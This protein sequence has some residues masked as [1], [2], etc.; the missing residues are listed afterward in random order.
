MGD[1]DVQAQHAGSP[2]RPRSPDRE[3]RQLQMKLDRQSR[4]LA[5]LEDQF[6]AIKVD[7][8]E[9]VAALEAQLQL[10]AGKAEALRQEVRRLRSASPPDGALSLAD[11]AELG[12][13]RRQ[14]ETLQQRLDASARREQAAAARS[15]DE[16]AAERE[17]LLKDTTEALYEWKEEC[18]HLQDLLQQHDR[19]LASA[20]DVSASRDDARARE[21]ELE[22]QAAL[23]EAGQE[24]EAAKKQSQARWDA[25]QIEYAKELE[26]REKNAGFLL[27]KV[28][29]IE[30]ELNEQKLARREATGEAQESLAVALEAGASL[31]RAYAA[32]AERCRQLQDDADVADND[33]SVLLDW[34]RSVMRVFSKL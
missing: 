27:E 13:L 9:A 11:D 3:A 34:S 16:Q 28:R 5:E 6:S 14:V 7:K 17:A 32:S 22:L 26:S 23:A 8:E 1:M 24:L 2:P 19:A 15:G 33:T 30:K 31:R 18:E 29:S 25:M 4:L 12:A 20:G 21:R 10:E